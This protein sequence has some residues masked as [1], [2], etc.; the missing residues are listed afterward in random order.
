FAGQEA[1]VALS[2]ANPPVA[3]AAQQDVL[4]RKRHPGQETQLLPFF[5]A[6]LI[7]YTSVQYMPAHGRPPQWT[8]TPCAP[9]G[10][11]AMREPFYPLMYAEM[12][13]N[14]AMAGYELRPPDDATTG[15]TDAECCFRFPCEKC[16]QVGLDYRPF[17]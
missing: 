14:L 5:F 4:S 3:L 15:A 1:G 8:G 10:G 9:R 17:C 7:I 16:G 11:A 13:L 2:G 6:P 12:A